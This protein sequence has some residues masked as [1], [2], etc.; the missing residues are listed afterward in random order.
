MIH[1]QERPH[2]R[3]RKLYPQGLE[4]VRDLLRAV[5][6]EARSQALERQHALRLGEVR[7]QLQGR[8]VAALADD[9][10]Q[11]LPPLYV[12]LDARELHLGYRGDRRKLYL[13]N[14]TK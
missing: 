10:L 6:V 11:L 5:E 7:I 9:L 12:E 2:L 3:V 13:R 8:P 4:S 1:L 14:E